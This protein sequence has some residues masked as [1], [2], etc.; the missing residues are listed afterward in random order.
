[1]LAKGGKPVSEEK[2]SYN[3]DSLSDPCSGD[4]EVEVVMDRTVL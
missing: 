4:S 1:M 2:I 3:S